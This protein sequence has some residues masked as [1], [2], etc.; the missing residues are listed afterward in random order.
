MN[1]AETTKLLQNRCRD[2][3]PGVQ[4]QIGALEPDQTLV[5]DAPR[6]A[7]QMRVRDDRDANQRTTNG[8]LITVVERS[9]FIDA[10]ILIADT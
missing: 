4:D 3:V 9:G 2:H 10:A 8:S 6:P 1:R 7:R 5:R